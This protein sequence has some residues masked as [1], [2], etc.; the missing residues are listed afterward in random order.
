MWLHFDD[1]PKFQEKQQLEDQ[2]PNTLVS[3]I[4]ATDIEKTTRCTSLDMT[5]VW[6]TRLFDRFIETA[7]S[8]NK[9]NR[10]SQGSDFRGVFLE[11]EPM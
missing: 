9:F 1:G 4:Y 3:E 11:I 10:M 6:R 5:T 8:R 2:T 7:I